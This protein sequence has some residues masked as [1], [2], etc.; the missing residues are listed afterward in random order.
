MVQGELSITI[1]SDNKYLYM[2]QKTL[3]EYSKWNKVRE[4]KKLHLRLKKVKQSLVNAFQD[5][6]HD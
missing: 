2:R 4:Y 3:D 5:N 1:S 6:S